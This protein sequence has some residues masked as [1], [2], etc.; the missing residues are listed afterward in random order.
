M[1]MARLIA[2]SLTMTLLAVLDNLL[3]I[4]CRLNCDLLA[5]VRITFFV[6]HFV[7]FIDSIAIE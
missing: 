3:A 4:S 2:S 7:N 1:P 5:T 6:R